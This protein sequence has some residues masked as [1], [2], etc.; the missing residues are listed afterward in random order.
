MKLSHYKN[1]FTHKLLMSTDKLVFK[2]FTG[3]CMALFKCCSRKYKESLSAVCLE[4]KNC[5][6]A[7]KAQ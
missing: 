3:V 4:R 5:K 7:K 1:N 2:L 6:V